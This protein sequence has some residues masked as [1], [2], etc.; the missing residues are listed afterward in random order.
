MQTTKEQVSAFMDSEMDPQEMDRL[1]ERMRDDSRLKDSWHDYHLIG[2]ALRR[3]LPDHISTDL[4]TRISA[5]IQNEPTHFLPRQATHK[6]SATSHR[7]EA[8]GFALAASVTAIAV[9]GVMQVNG[10]EQ[11]IAQPVTVAALER[12]ETAQ[13]SAVGTVASVAQD[14]QVAARPDREVVYASVTTEPGRIHARVAVHKQ[15]DDAGMDYPQE[16]A[17]LYDYL[18]NYNEYARTRSLQGEMYPA[19][20]LVGYTP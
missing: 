3:Q 13:T 18:V 20:Q 17:D 7:K 19:I 1:I 6:K 8:L 4:H 2:D 11:G 14:Q 12:S 16:A 9:V 10:P 15:M 5:A